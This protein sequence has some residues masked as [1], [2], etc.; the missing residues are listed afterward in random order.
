MRHNCTLLPDRF[1]KLPKF[2]EAETF[3]DL[4]EN[5]R[6]NK[7]QS[8]QIKAKIEELKKKHSDRLV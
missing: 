5:N 4:V 7:K 2:T 8:K 1:D 3:Q 6:F